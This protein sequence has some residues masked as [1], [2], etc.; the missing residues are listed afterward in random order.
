MEVEHEVQ[1]LLGGGR[2]A[3]DQVLDGLHGGLQ[4]LSGAVPHTV[5]VSAEQ[6]ALGVISTLY[7]QLD[8]I[9]NYLYLGVAE[10]DPIR[11]HHGHDLE[12]ELLPEEGGHL[13]LGHQ[14][15]YQTLQP[16]THHTQTPNINVDRY[17]LELMIL[18]LTKP[19]V[20]YD[21]CNVPISRLL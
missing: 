2:E 1:R 9:D 16:V 13:V 12:D 11:V 20:S 3:E 4:E 21:L 15:V 10:E 7:I 19:P 5:Q 17:S 6:R 8:I 18:S 14:E